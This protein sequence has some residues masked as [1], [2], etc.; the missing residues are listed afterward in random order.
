MGSQ[1]N[2]IDIALNKGAVFGDIANQ[3]P[4]GTKAWMLCL[5]YLECDDA[6]VVRGGNI[7]L[8]STKDRSFVNKRRTLPMYCVLIEHPHEGL[9]L[10]ETGSGKDYPEVWGPQLA[11]IFSRVKYEPQHELEAAIAST[12]HSYKDVKHIIIGHLHLDHAGGL[13]IFKGMNVPIWVHEREL[14]AA[15]YS[16]AT[17]ADAGVYLEHYLDMKSNW[18]TFSE[19]RIDFAQGLTLWHL[20]GHTDGSL[21]LQL[22]L[23]RD[24][25]YIFIGDLCH[26]AENYHEGIPQ[27]W[28][29]RDHPA[30]F[31]SIQKIKRLESRTKGLVVMGHDNDTCNIVWDKMKRDGALSRGDLVSPGAGAIATGPLVRKI[32]FTVVAADDLLKREVF[33]LPDVFCAVHVYPPGAAYAAPL[34]SLATPIVRNTLNPYWSHP[35]EFDAE[36]GTRILIRVHDNNKYKKR[37]QGFLG[38]VTLATVG[39]ILPGNRTGQV[40]VTRD[41][42]K[43]S[44]NIAVQGKLI[45][46]IS[47]DTLARPV[48]PHAA[49]LRSPNS[50]SPPINSSTRPQLS[51]HSA[52]PSSRSH[53]QN[54]SL[55]TPVSGPGPGNPPLLPPKPPTPV[56]SHPQTDRRPPRHS[57]RQHLNPQTLRPTEE[58][59][60]VTRRMTLQE[61]RRGAAAVDHN[62][63]T[64]TWDD[65]RMPS[66]AGIDQSK[67]DFRRKL[68]YFRSQ[69]AQRVLNGECRI[70]VRREHLFEDA[71][72]EVM[73]HPASEL[74]KR[75]M[76]T[77]KG[78]EGLDY[79]GVSREFFFLLSHAIFDPSF[80]LFENTNKGNYTLMFNP[81]SGVNPEH[82]DYFNF[83]G[84]AV[85]LAIFHR[86]FIDAH[87]APSIYKLILGKDVGVEEMALIDADLHQSLQ[88]MLE[89]DITEAGLENDFVDEFEVFGEVQQI[90][91]VPNG[92]NTPVTEENKAEYIKLLCQ[93]RLK[94]RV[95][96]QL[97]SFKRGL[98]EIIHKDALAV[99]DERELELLIG[100]LSEI[101][102]D[103]WMKNTEY[104]GYQQEDE[105]VVWFWEAVKSWPMEKKSRLLQF[106]TGTS[107]TPVNGFRD[108]QGSD[109]PR[110]FTIE[111]SGTINSLPKTHTCFNRL[112]LPPY[113]SREVLEAKLVFALEETSGFAQE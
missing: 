53:S 92:S 94:G 45:L 5:G 51:P 104:R 27:G 41:L 31:N 76:I 57:S 50:A 1:S 69:P 80:C 7:S 55:R 66:D 64:T 21:G 17:G 49:H 32:K 6:F 73:K 61:H 63:K 30:W 96:P 78:E 106:T 85:G 90:D 44:E 28:L 74:K 34:H 46:Q 8:T 48:A 14:K 59:S 86:R 65:P 23:P 20:P 11:D 102:V 13:D 19:D 4:P 18:K 79:G 60:G 83:I 40:S 16:V 26:V 70:T 9:I 54:G 12:G 87:F 75:L 95:E 109:G 58:R 98:H 37:D 111:K 68:V 84:R 103:D 88:W 67:R 101:D 112:D 36:D 38:E 33:K 35:F 93:H 56:N 47:A 99:F 107:R 89:N 2:A 22:N 91:L 43:S 77:F 105:V 10:W 3:C 100:G 29:A 42:E 97:Q 52:G 71:F 39:E 15:Y 62:T 72:A 108:L 25:T 82:L 113:E 110:K 81:N 24:G